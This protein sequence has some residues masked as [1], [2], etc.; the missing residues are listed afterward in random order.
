MMRSEEKRGSPVCG[1]WITHTPP[2]AGG[3]IRQWLEKPLINV[4]ADR[5]A[6]ERGG[7]ALLRNRP[8][9]GRACRKALPGVFDMER[10]I[11]RIVYG[12]GQ[13]P[14]SARPVRRPARHL[15]AA[16]K[17]P[18]RALTAASAWR[19]CARQI[20][21]LADVADLIDRAIVEEPPFSVREGGMIRPGLSAKSSTS[22]ADLMQGGQG[23]PGRHRAAGAGAHR[24]H[25]AESGLQQGVRLLH[26]D[27]QVLRR[28]GAG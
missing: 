16:S 21:P 20:D 17:E 8:R 25:Q 18:G 6:A 2:W 24:H 14:G 13:L 1:C 12:I 9:R 22:C 15:P 3:C 10:L 5:A 4:A 26:R 23:H 11:G 28:P 19:S 7:R 27:L